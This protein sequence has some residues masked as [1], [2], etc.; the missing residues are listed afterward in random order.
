MYLLNFANSFIV[1]FFHLLKC[2]MLVFV[3]ILLFLTERFLL[4]APFTQNDS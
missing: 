1:F 3:I 4:I 2:N